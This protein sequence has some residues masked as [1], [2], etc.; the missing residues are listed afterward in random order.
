MR[1]KGETC[2]ERY[3]KGLDGRSP[4]GTGFFPWWPQKNE[5]GGQSAKAATRV[6]ATSVCNRQWGGGPSRSPKT[7]DPSL[8]DLTKNQ[9]EG[10]GKR[11][12]W[13]G[14]VVWGGGGGGGGGPRKEADLSLPRAFKKKTR[15]R[16]VAYKGGI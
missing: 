14:G 6:N 13:G 12:V 7:V 2:A 16:G 11:C 3:R 15:C 1:Q 5:E 10:E 8:H 4:T 9:R